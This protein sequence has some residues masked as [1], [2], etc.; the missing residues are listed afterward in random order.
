MFKILH[1]RLLTGVTKLFVVEAPLVARRAQPGQF[2]IVRVRE[3]GE[4]IPLT[5]ADYDRSAGTVTIVVQEVGKTTRLLGALEEGEAILDV[6]GPLGRPAELPETGRV[7]LVG[8][9]FGVAP[10]LPKARALKERGVHVTSVIGARNADLV[11]L[12]E[13]LGARSD[14]MLVATDDGSRGRKGLVTDVLRDLLDAGE[15]VDEVIAIGPMIMMQAVAEATRPA[16]IRTLVSV[17]PIMVDGTGMCG[18]CRVTVGGQTRFACVDGPIF[19]G[20]AVDFAE[21]I[22]RGRMY[23]AEEQEALRVWEAAGCPR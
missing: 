11:I 20:H 9:G 13:E 12:E 19:D 23:R 22:R 16:G 14:R 8:G 18:A 3:P 4:R 15:V 10:L 1:K 21:A 2:L 5:I 6:V 17:N 7:V